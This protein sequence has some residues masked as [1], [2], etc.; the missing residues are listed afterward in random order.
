MNRFYVYALMDPR[1]PG[2]WEYS[3]Y[4]SKGKIVF[5]FKPFYIGKGRG[6]RCHSH[7]AE[8]L[9]VEGRPNRKQAK[10]RKILK[11]GLTVRV[12]KIRTDQS[13]EQALALEERII[14]GVGKVQDGGPL[15]NV[16]DGGTANANR[17][18]TDEHRRKLSEA[19]SGMEWTASAKERLKQGWASRT[20]K[21]KD[22][23]ARKY[24]D[25][26]KQKSQVD[27]DA[28]SVSKS[29]SMKST[30][31][32]R[33]PKKRTSIT[34]AASK[35]RAR[36][37]VQQKMREGLRQRNA[38]KTTCPHCQKSGQENAMR[39]WHFDNCKEINRGVRR[40]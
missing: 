39:R 19:K 7:V 13:E 28:L 25:T 26:W 8:A 17:E 30:W 4:G 31:A 6:K 33:D 5:P 38:V 36:P 2:N 21:Q 18:F 32:S 10:I 15:T 16:G 22:E 9:R 29:E 11:L 3:L 37:E 27:M 34:E 23:T 35:A 20:E 14:R 12:Q 1:H 24:R 40:T